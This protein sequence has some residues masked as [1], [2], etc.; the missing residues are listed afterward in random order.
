MIELSEP[1][2]PAP[3]NS[4]IVQTEAEVQEDTKDTLPLYWF[5]LGGAVLGYLATQL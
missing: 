2:Y 5:F 4:S 3:K 1:V